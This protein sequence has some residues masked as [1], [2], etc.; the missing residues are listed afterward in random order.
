MVINFILF[1]VF[2]KMAADLELMTLFDGQS[3]QATEAVGDGISDAVLRTM[4]ALAE[5]RRR[6]TWVQEC[7]NRLT[8]LLPYACHPP[9]AFHDFL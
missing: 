9:Y 5:H 8:N 7:Q 1:S 3:S 4:G 2:A 6:E